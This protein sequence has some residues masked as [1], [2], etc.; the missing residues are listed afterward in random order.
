MD[1]AWLWGRISCCAIASIV[2][3]SACHAMSLMSDTGGDGN[4]TSDV[5]SDDPEVRQESW[6]YVSIPRFGFAPLQ[7]VLE[8]GSPANIAMLDVGEPIESY[9]PVPVHGPTANT[10]NAALVFLMLPERCLGD[11]NYDGVVDLYDATLFTIAFVNQDPS[12]DLTRDGRID[13]RDQILFVTLA[14]LPC[15]S[16]W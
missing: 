3:S 4:N 6:V 8:Y 16:A 14:T 13:I 10:N 1:Q 15:Y 9:E 2:L 7:D 12:A 5:D 11:F